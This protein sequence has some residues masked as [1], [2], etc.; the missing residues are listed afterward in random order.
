LKPRLSF[1]LAVAALLATLLLSSCGG[2]GGGGGI[3]GG[4]NNEVITQ[5]EAVFASNT[6][7]AVDP[8]NLQVGDS[9]KFQL[10]GYDAGGVRT[11][12]S[13]SGWLTTDPFSTVGTLNA[14]NGAYSATTASGTTF[15][16][17]MDFNGT[18]YAR[19]YKV[20]PVQARI[21]GVISSQSSGVGIGGVRVLL[22][23][24]ANALVGSVTT[25]QDGTFIASAPTTA[26][27]FNLDPNSI[28]LASYYRIFN[29]SGIARGKIAGTSTGGDFTLAGT[30]S[31]SNAAMTL[32]D[33]SKSW[34]SNA[35]V[36]YGVSITSGTGVGQS[37]IIASNTATALNL[38]TTWS[39]TPDA[40]S[41]YTINGNTLTDT[42]ANW[43]P[44]DLQTRQIV[45]SAGTGAGQNRI[46]TG[47]TATQLTV[48]Q[49]W[50]IAPDS[51][52]VY[53]FIAPRFGTLASPCNAELPTPL[54]NGVTT[55]MKGSITLPS[56]SLPPPAP[57]N[58]CG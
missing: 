19:P 18:N 38:T 10:V 43:L 44:G 42:T 36:G 22:Y 14:A 47:N 31:G 51:T 49:P 33:T 39:T 7:Q 34:A 46:V 20:N 40:T 24:G 28:A 52:S 58:G 9:V 8:T 23:N 41:T 12:L 32:N 6:S 2:G 29:Y 21:S 55:P 4:G 37:R 16:I 50:D 45:I 17:S 25:A 26:V 1:F 30:S 3:G 48:S 11:V 15:Q 35:F 57:P 5:I 54:S 56:T 53:S 13:T 27:G